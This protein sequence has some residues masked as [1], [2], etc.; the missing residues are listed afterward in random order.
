MVDTNYGSYNWYD[1]NYNWY[2]TNY[3]GDGLNQDFEK[4]Y[5]EENYEPYANDVKHAQRL[6]GG[7]NWLSTRTRPD[8]SFTVSQLSSAAARAPLRAPAIT[9]SG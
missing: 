2:D 4:W 6:A 7:L 1:N 5:E 9:A 3:N 8:I